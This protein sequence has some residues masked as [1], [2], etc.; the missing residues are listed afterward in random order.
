MPKSPKRR[1]DTP[2]TSIR[3]LV[4]GGGGREHA[5]AWRLKKSNAVAA[6]FTTH[7]GNPG[8]RSIAQP[9]D[10]DF[11][12][13]EIYRV[14]QFV[15]RHDINLIVVGP[16][17]P[18]A[19]G[20]VDKL[21][22]IERETGV[23]VLGPTKQAAQLEA[24]KAWAK[25]V[26]RAAGAPTAQSHVYRDVKGAID[27]LRS[28]ESPYVVKASGLAAGKGVVVPE[29]IDDAEAAVRM[30]MQ[31]RR[32]GDAGAQVVI[33]ERLDGPEVSVFALV[34]GANVVLLDACQ[35]HKRLREGDDGPNT[36]GMGAYC[37]PPRELFGADQFADV[38][39]RVVV[40]VIDA[41]K[42]DGIDYR[43]VLY[44]GL[45]LTR[46]GPRVLEFNVRF[47]DPEC[48]CLVRRITGDFGMLLWHTA[49]GTL[50]HADFGY[51]DDAVVCTVL[52]AEGYPDAPVKGA[53]IVGLDDAESISGV[54][55]FHAGTARREGKLVTN[56]G[57]VLNITAAAPTVAEARE[58][59]N[60]ACEKVHFTGM[61]W[62]RDIAE[63][64]IGEH[65]AKQ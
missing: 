23:R 63:Q 20:V 45:M 2:P 28:R 11:S 9:V 14:E 51:N 18:L 57:R 29:T 32:F 59:V 12:V 39:R 65:A 30:M 60:A 22:A 62:R 27:F 4:I 34:D 10:F 42:R 38:A 61:Q 33:E 44:V 64:A 47:G 49:D 1:R 36:G 13:R 26:M 53:E 54:E 56:G 21:A 6:V 17:Q 19:D 52:A 37:P 24:D 40:P 31:D 43:G 25:K 15:R 48:Q 3:A 46:S 41:L 5:L 7:P 35:D 58:R 50:D 55:V 8:L 16:E